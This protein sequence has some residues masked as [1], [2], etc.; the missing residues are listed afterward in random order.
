M[1]P[2]VVENGF[3]CEDPEFAA[4]RAHARECFEG[5]AAKRGAAVAAPDAGAGELDEGTLTEK[6]ADKPIDLAA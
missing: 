4:A 5:P 3:R 1:I 2:T 6:L